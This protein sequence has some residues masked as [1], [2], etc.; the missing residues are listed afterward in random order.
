MKIAAIILLLF[1]AFIFADD[2]VI[3]QARKLEKDKKIDDA[4]QLLKDYDKQH[5]NDVDVNEALQRIMTHNNRK[6]QA[7]KE[8]K[9]RYDAQPNG[10]NAYL[11]GHLID[12]P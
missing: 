11:Y 6:D 7:V 12:E 9:Q 1:G 10:L 2:S 5:P 3:D 8:Y 4:I